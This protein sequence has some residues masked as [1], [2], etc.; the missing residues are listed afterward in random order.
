MVTISRLRSSGHA[1]HTPSARSSWT[2]HDKPTARN[3]LGF[4]AHSDDVAAAV[5]FFASEDSRFVTGTILQANGGIGL[6]QFCPPDPPPPTAQKPAT[7]TGE[8]TSRSAPVANQEEE[9]A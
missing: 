5:A 7:R 1:N 6:S 8:T 3:P 9:Q 4:I 2:S